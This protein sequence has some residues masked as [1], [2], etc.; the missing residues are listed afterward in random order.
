MRILKETLFPLL[1]CGIEKLAFKFFLD[2]SGNTFEQDIPFCTAANT[3]HFLRMFVK[4]NNIWSF[5]SSVLSLLHLEY[6]PEPQPQLIKHEWSGCSCHLHIIFHHT[7][8]CSLNPDPIAF[9]LGECVF[10]L[11]TST[12]VLHL[13]RLLAA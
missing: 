5:H 12:W 3:I 10:V 7:F 4:N 1:P 13:S 11:V 6:N 9:L 8:T 2:L